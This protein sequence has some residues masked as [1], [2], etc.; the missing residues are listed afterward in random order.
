MHTEHILHV[1]MDSAVGYIVEKHSISL[2][3]DE[4]IARF[5]DAERVGGYCLTCNRYGNCWACPPYSFDVKE[6]LAQYSTITI[7]V[8]KLIPQM[9]DSNLTGADRDVAMD[10]ELNTP[11]DEVR[12]TPAEAARSIPPENVKRIVGELI[13]EQRKKDDSFLLKKEREESGRAFFAGTCLLCPEGQ[14]AKAHGKP[15]LFPDKVRPSLEACGF[16]VVAT[17]SALFG[18]EMKWGQEGRL[19][20]YITLISGFAKKST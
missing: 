3:M 11:T 7:Y 15:C 18:I 14:C 10:T 12:H 17:A 16:D 2:R 20:E 6:Y 13:R 19:P 1:I 9:T 8:S 4:Y 5:R